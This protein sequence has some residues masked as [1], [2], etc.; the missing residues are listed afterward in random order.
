MSES[1]NDHRH[2]LDFF[3]VCYL[4]DVNDIEAA[5]SGIAILPSYPRAV[6]LNLFGN[7]LCQFEEM[8]RIIEGLR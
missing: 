3:R 2:L 7:L 6:A 5:E 1:P 8:F 4:H